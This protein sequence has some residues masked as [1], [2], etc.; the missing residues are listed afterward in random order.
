MVRFSELIKRE[1]IDTSQQK[2]KPA[3]QEEEKERSREPGGEVAT[4]PERGGRGADIGGRFISRT[5]PERQPAR[6]GEGEGRA[7]APSA[8][9]S[10]RPSE[11]S[12]LSVDDFVRSQANSFYLS[13]V[14]YIE[15]QL[16]HVIEDAPI[17]VG[18]GEECVRQ[19]IDDPKQCELVG[20][21]ATLGDVSL[22]WLA[23]NMANVCIYSLKLAHGMQRHP[24]QE[25][26]VLGMAA[27]LHDIGV[28]K[29]PE[30]V[31]NK[32]GAFTPKEYELMQ[33]HPQIGAQLVAGLG[34]D[35]KEVAAVILQEHERYGGQGYPRGLRGE[36]IHPFALIIGLVDVFDAMVSPR[37]HRKRF[38]PPY[39]VKFVIESQRDHFDPR[40]LKRFVMEFSM[41]PLNS[42]VRL[43]TRA[44]GR[45]A[46]I[47]STYA[48]RPTVEIICDS[49]GRRLGVPQ[50]VDL[51][52]TPMLYII[53]NVDAEDMPD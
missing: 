36:A 35:Y 47:N 24:P 17:E 7:A 10:R 34:D 21:R 3:E 39:A 15:Q 53:D 46:R 49:H 48:M 42:L 22:D 6:S 26:R 33:H 12:S 4:S 31:V 45:V 8:V 14:E 9:R 51:A 20:Y 41:F 50:V 29:I 32:N 37:P 1:M 18:P 16:R 40:L 28:A 11:A 38:S 23:T 19:L 43:N 2:R 25:L 52:E 27:L 5:A 30:A 13:M 44:I